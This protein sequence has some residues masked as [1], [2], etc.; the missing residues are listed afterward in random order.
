[1]IKGTSQ[2]TTTD[3]AGNYAI[4]VPDTSHLVFSF[5]GMQTK[6]L[7]VADKRN[8]DMRMMED[9][10]QLAEVVIARNPV[11]KQE[12]DIEEIKLAEPVGGLRAYDKY[13]NDNK[14]YPQQ[15]LDA[16][17]K[18][19]VI[20]AFDVGIRGE[21]T[22]FSVIRGLGYGC[23]EE[24]IRLI[25]QGPAWNPTTEANVPVESTVHVKMKFDAVKFKK[26]S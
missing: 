22:N 11:P 24:V 7:T 1:M 16:D 26:K 2:G 5:V 17:V 3:V 13:L 25:K 4:E 21:L 18:G 23:E 10:T 9:A 15:A 20:I 12:G 6:E 14:T 8:V 19:R